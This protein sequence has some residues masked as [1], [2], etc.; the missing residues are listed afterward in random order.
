MERPIE[1]IRPEDLA[2]Y[3]PE[4]HSETVNRRLLKTDKV[5]I[6]LGRMMRGGAAQGHIH[7]TTDQIVFILNGT[8]S[9]VKDG[10]IH[11]IGPET[12]LCFP[13]GTFHGGAV[14]LNRTDQLLSFLVIYSPPLD[15]LD[16]FPTGDYR[17]NS[18]I[19]LISPDR[20]I[21]YQRETEAE[22]QDRV[23]LR[24]K[25]LEISLSQVSNG[26]IIEE[27]TH[28]VNDQV[29]YVIHGTGDLVIDGKPVNME[30]GTL[31]LIPKGMPHGGKL[32][33]NRM[34]SILKSLVI[35]TPPLGTLP[36]LAEG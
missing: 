22:T 8:G 17:A 1:I 20:V 11:E 14:P 6:I 23:L 7:K 30:H 25:N 5:E 33:T 34:S 21:P 35:Y 10:H 28:A 26:G 2:P 3:Q 19:H 18:S 4:G 29:L 27:H 9:V 31:A 24:T 36:Q 12:L 15:P 32:P 13:A 16:I